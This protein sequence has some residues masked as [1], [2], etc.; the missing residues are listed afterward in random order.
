MVY[1]ELPEMGSEVTKGETFGVVESVKVR[2]AC[3]LGPQRDTVSMR[4]PTLATLSAAGC[5]RR[6]LTLERG[7][8]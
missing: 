5:Q 7:S 1:V 4:G 6:I 2:M 8:C 3:P